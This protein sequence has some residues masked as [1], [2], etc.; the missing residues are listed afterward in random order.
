MSDYD[1]HE[2]GRRRKRVS[3]NMSGDDDEE[4]DY[5]EL[6]TLGSEGAHHR[7]RGE[8][9]DDD[10]LDEEEDDDDDDDEDDEEEDYKSSKSGKQRK[11]RRVQANSFL[12]VEAT[13]DSEEDEEEED[14]EEGLD[15]IQDDDAAE[16]AAAAKE[17]DR[18][19]AF[20]QRREAA[21]DEMSAEELAQ[22]IKDRYSDYGMRRDTGHHAM[23]AAGG[24]ESG[25][26]PR[27]LMVP[28]V[29]DPHLWMVK[30]RPGKERDVVFMIM[31]RY[32]ERK[33]GV[34]PMGIFSAYCR[35]GL[36]GYVYLE[37]KN[38]AAAQSSLD[39][40]SGIIGSKL[41]LIPI[42]Q[43]QDV[44][45]VKKQATTLKEGAWVRVRRGKYVGD[46]AQVISISDSLDMVEVKLVPRLDYEK[47]SNDPNKKPKK[48]FASS[49]PANRPPQKL[50]NP[51]E[52]EKVDRS[53]PVII[54]GHYFVWGADSFRDGYLEK[55]MKITSLITADINPSL[56]EITQFAQ[57]NLEADDADP[58]ATL[59]NLASA[60]A[61]A[62]AASI[63]ADGKPKATDLRTNDHVEIIEGDM[64]GV[65]GTVRSIEGDGVV[66]VSL[67]LGGLLK[68][69]QTSMSFPAH[70]LRKR[71]REGD[72]VQV[73]NG[74]FKDEKGMVISIEESIVTILS[75]LNLNEIKVFAK[76][77][78]EST[79][80]ATKPTAVA[81]QVEL[82][83]MVS[84]EGQVVGVVIKI[85]N[86]SLK[87]LDQN[88][89]VRRMK[90]DQ[91]T[92]MRN[93]S[94]RNVAI[95]SQGNTVTTGDKIREV[96]GAQRQGTVIQLNRFVTFAQSR[97]IVENNGIFAVRTRN[98]VNV[99]VKPGVGV[100]GQQQQQGYGSNGG[101]M[102]QQQQQ[103]G[104]GRGRG[105]GGRGSFRGGRDRL[106]GKSVHIVRG[107]YK[108]YL[109]I[110]KDSTDMMARV[111]LHTNARIVNIEKDK[112]CIKGPNGERI[113]VTDMQAP[114]A[115]SAAAGG[116]RPGAGSS[117]GWG[118]RNSSSGGRGG[119][120]YG[121]GSE[122]PRWG[123]GGYDNDGGRT[124]AWSGGN[125]SRGSYSSVMSGAR[126][127]RW[128]ASTPSEGPET[129]GGAWDD[130]GG[131]WA[132]GAKTPAWGGN[133]PETPGMPT[134]GASSH[135]AP[136]ETPGG[137]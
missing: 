126:T 116:G 77:L 74:R 54:R 92:P 46:L 69:K 128:Q 5:D 8:L 58:A 47:S 75:D 72:H 1:L 62:T 53:K 55:E 132:S 11:R 102:G 133:V 105:R 41:T 89:D 107:P 103:R 113:P 67:D 51:C 61:A 42:D 78:C 129:P 121:S 15:F 130:G 99:A 63:S 84:L 120:S 35:D 90:P 45:T 83:D 124:P 6:G 37:A 76:D 17:A 114:T 104:R 16:V 127:P 101:S 112:L 24:A 27:V 137:W 136:P 86:D 19:R 108:G 40:I 26:T 100:L 134:P 96:G 111:E 64:A 85:E 95:D 56:E 13:V 80:S 29:N 25:W 23:A 34:N 33:N 87:I 2:E 135:N 60:A 31:K 68:D 106:I 131:A 59:S 110:V 20:A 10:D 44:V 119:S 66:R 43:M 73:L 48:P 88:G 28:S 71:F 81:G 123:G 52:A 70:H 7:Q 117:D 93:N 32:F 38:H 118:S 82:Q 109:G 21:T 36:S 122:T 4:E 57:G 50:F 18:H 91:I 49:N 14:D 22:K 97:E 39:K 12:D 65:T 98:V 9:D 115:S 30:C 94:R 79:D 3:A 125:N